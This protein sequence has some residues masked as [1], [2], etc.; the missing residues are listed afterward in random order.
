MNGRGRHGRVWH[1]GLANCLTLS[2][3]WRF[4]RDLT[5]LAGLSLVVGL[6]IVR[7][8]RFFSAEDIR[9]KW[10]NDII[11]NNEKLAGILTEIKSIDGSAF[12]VIG[13]GI[14]FYLP[15]SLRL[16]INQ[17][18]TD[19]YQITGRYLNRN[20]LLGSL[21]SELRSTLE[22]FDRY[23]FQI[24][25]DEWTKNHAYEDCFVSLKLPTGERIDGIVRGVNDAGALNL[26]TCN[27]EHSYNIGDVSLR[28]KSII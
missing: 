28:L 6:A 20:H 27:G 15:D 12:A 25:K 16:L 9:L 21:L 3:L 23:G 5:H 4:D 17:D 13:I 19:L 14:N 1:S 11:F 7:S 8:L 26:A 18:I 24:F 22:D 2:V 10:P